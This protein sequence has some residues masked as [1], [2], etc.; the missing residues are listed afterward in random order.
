MMIII[1]DKRNMD[2]IKNVAKFKYVNPEPDTNE[3][4]FKW[5]F[6]VRTLING[7]KMTVE[8]MD[9]L[10][11]HLKSLT[12]HQHFVLTK[13]RAVLEMVNGVVEAYS[14]YIYTEIHVLN[15]SIVLKLGIDMAQLNIQKKQGNSI[16]QD[17]DDDD[18][19]DMEEKKKKKTDKEGKNYINIDNNLN[20]IDL[21]AITTS[22]DKIWNFIYTPNN[23]IAKDWYRYHEV[24]LSNA[25]GSNVKNWVHRVQ[26][27]VVTGAKVLSK[28][29]SKPSSWLEL[30]NQTKR[31]HMSKM[32]M[33]ILLII[34]HVEGGGRKEE[35]RGGKGGGGW[36]R[37]KKGKNEKKGVM[38]G[39]DLNFE[40]KQF[41]LT[42][43]NPYL[44]LIVLLQMS[45]YNQVFSTDNLRENTKW[46]IDR[47]IKLMDFSWIVANDR[48]TNKVMNTNIH[49]SSAD[50]MFRILN[51]WLYISL[52][53]LSSEIADFWAWGSGNPVFG[54]M[55]TLHQDTQFT[56]RS[57]LFHIIDFTQD[58]LKP[59]LDI[60]RNIGAIYTID[61]VIVLNN[62]LR[63]MGHQLYNTYGKLL[64]ISKLKKENPNVF[65]FMAKN[66]TITS[67]ATHRTLSLREINELYNIYVGKL[68]TWKRKIA[69]IDAANIDDSVKIP[70]QQQQ[71][72][73]DSLKK[74]EEITH[75]LSYFTTIP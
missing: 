53:G 37:G 69:N 36:K 49:V 57:I 31:H 44:S 39:I 41:I 33:I 3:G 1:E 6:Y 22:W 51:Q 11:A 62:K 19:D 47:Y 26:Y 61:Y 50:A 2:H 5:R 71:Q 35:K 43:T 17:D 24:L 59:H 42:Q 4:T 29:L 48:T 30:L 70:Q 12:R 55:A 73:E 25:L 64:V 7:Y 20:D 16:N 74:I 63:E 8:V 21:V 56:I 66:P 54:K 58:T 18:D 9:K 13:P 67:S 23:P 75:I 32:Q 27:A 14:T 65:K 68:S 15:E 60:R 34:L 40:L 10:I 72:K 38:G 52:G 45:R 28:N 46:W